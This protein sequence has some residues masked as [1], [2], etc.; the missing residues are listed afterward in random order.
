METF[1][2]W[3][4]KLH[5]FLKFQASATRTLLRIAHLSVRELLFHKM[6]GSCRWTAR[7]VSQLDPGLGVRHP[8]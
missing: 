3:S 5:K 1:E 2:A 7:S 6:A 8:S 4:E